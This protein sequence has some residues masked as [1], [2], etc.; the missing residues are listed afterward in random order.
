MIGLEQVRMRGIGKGDVETMGFW[1][2][3]LVGMGL[4]MPI[5]V[6]IRVYSS[7]RNKNEDA[8]RLRAM[9]LQWARSN[10]DPNGG[11]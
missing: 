5:F 3:V 11:K 8:K 2:G 9:R 10:E 7:R 1:T 4:I 6:S